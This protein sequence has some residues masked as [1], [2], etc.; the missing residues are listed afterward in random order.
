MPLK[1]GVERQGNVK[2]TEGSQTFVVHIKFEVVEAFTYTCPYA[3][4]FTAMIR[5]QTNAPTL[6][7]ALDTDMAQY[8]NL[9]ITP[10]EIGLVTLTG[11][12]L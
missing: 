10:D 4:K 8:D 1:V 12:W 9:V 5:Q 2:I 3:L 11:I 7:I 6:S